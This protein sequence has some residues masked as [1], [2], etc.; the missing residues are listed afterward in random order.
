MD[1]MNFI[2]T[3]RRPGLPDTA[4]PGRWQ[5]ALTSFATMA[6]ITL[7]TFAGVAALDAHGMVPA[8]TVE[9]AYP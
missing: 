6:A 2:I 8:A 1:G 7:A 3:G 5:E 9:G 4:G